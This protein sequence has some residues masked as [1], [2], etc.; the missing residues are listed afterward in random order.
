[1][2]YGISFNGNDTIGDVS[3][4]PQVRYETPVQQ[5]PEADTVC[6]KGKDEKKK[7]SIGKTI[8]GLVTVAAV[9]I[10]GLAYAHKA[11]WISK[12]KDGKIKT[13]LSSAAET[14]YGWYEKS[15]KSVK[16]YYEK[17]KNY[18]HKKS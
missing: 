16:K 13:K 17:V 11:N 14:C 6:F 9:T 5:A 12:L 1:M 7:S 15:S 8:L 18:F 3:T 4:K 10:G 2:V